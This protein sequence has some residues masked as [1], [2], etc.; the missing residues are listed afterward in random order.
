MVSSQFGKDDAS[1]DDEFEFRVTETILRDDG[2]SRYL[3][4]KKRLWKQ[5]GPVNNQL[6]AAFA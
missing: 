6:S 1:D 3:N 2:L 4:R 5:Q